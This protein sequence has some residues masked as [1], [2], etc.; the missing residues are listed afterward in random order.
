EAASHA[1]RYL[2]IAE[3]GEKNLDQLRFISILKAECFDLLGYY[4][5]GEQSIQSMIAIQDHPDL[6]L[7]LVN[8]KATPRERIEQMNKVLNMYHLAPTGFQ[9]EGQ[10][11][12]NL[13]TSLNE[14]N[15][16]DGPKVSIILPAYN[17]E[18]GII[19]AIES[20]LT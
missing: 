4:K 16:A 8:L 14:L 12:D 2:R 3:T 18:I 20:I 7:A 19:T 15:V 5:A 9:G 1:L 17:A 10:S 11:Y 6:H 13:I